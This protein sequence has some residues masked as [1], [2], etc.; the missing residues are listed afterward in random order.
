[1]E[2]KHMAE[3]LGKKIERF[4]QDVWK[5]TTDVVGAIG[6]SAE[7]ANKKRELKAVYSDIGQTF[8]AKH[9]AQAADDSPD[10]TER[11]KALETEIADLEAQILEQ[12]GSKK[13]VSCGEMIPFEAAFCSKCGA[14]Q[15]KAEPEPESEPTVEAEVIDS[16]I[17]P[18]CGAKL[19]ST[20]AFCTVCGVKRP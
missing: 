19:G 10:L 4:G 15:P 18:A 11:A 2:G 20:D 6:K 1:M 7:V 12:R 16:W 17:C 8:L 14:A 9:P 13:C 5:K 3:E